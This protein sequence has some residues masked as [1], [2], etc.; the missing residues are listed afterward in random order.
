MVVIYCRDNIRADSMLGQARRKHSR[1]ADGLKAGMNLKTDPRP[2]SFG[3]DVDRSQPLVFAN[4][5]ELALRHRAVLT[6]SEGVAVRMQPGFKAL[7]KP[8]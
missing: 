6:R 8:R 1:Q 3:I 4:E 2:F 7:Q 5:G